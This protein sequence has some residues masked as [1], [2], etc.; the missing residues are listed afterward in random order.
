MLLAIVLESVHRVL[1]CYSGWY[2][3]CENVM[4]GSGTDGAFG[5]SR[6]FAC[7]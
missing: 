2:V 6:L 3:R 5:I 4:H 1:L 7:L